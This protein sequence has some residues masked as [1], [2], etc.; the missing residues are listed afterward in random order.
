MRNGGNPEHISSV[1]MRC[2]RV[3]AEFQD[4][5]PEWVQML[6]SGK[7]EVESDEDILAWIKTMQIQRDSTASGEGAGR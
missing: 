2:L 1:L 6:M 3:L 4:I 7:I 5:E